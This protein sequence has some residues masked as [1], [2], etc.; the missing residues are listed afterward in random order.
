MLALLLTAVMILTP[1]CSAV[2]AGEYSTKLPFHDTDPEEWY[3]D[4]I[5]YVFDENLMMGKGGG[6]FAPQSGMTRAE[7]ATMLSRMAGADVTG[8][9]EKAKGFSDITGSEWHAAYIGWA[10]EAKLLS[11]YPDGTMKPDNPILRQEI[12]TIISRFV[13]SFGYTLPS[14]VE[15][16]EFDDG[17]DIAEYA[18]P[19]VNRLAAAGIIKGSGG[20]FN[21]QI[22]LTRA[23]ASKIIMMLHGF[24][25]GEEAR[26]T[27]SYDRETAEEYKIWGA[28]HLYYAGT[29]YCGNM[30]STLDES[31]ELP[32]MKFEDCEGATRD[33]QAFMSGNTA[34]APWYIGVNTLILKMDTAKYP[35]LSFKLKLGTDEIQPVT[36]VI[37][38]DAKSISFVGNLLPDGKGYHSVHIDLT[39]LNG[40]TAFPEGSEKFIRVK[41]YPFGDAAEAGN[42]SL[43]YA[44]FFKELDTALSFDA[45][46]ISDYMNTY[47]SDHDFDWREL[48]STA[49]TKYDDAVSARIDDIMNAESIDPATITGKCYY[50]SSVNGD[51]SNTGTSPD[52]PWKTFENLYKW[53]AN[54]TILLNVPKSGDG[55]FLE[56]GSVFYSE[57]ASGD[58]EYYGL[59]VPNGVTL[60]AYGEGD[61]PLITHALDVEGSMDWSKTEYDNIWVLDRKIIMP[62]GKPYDLDVGNI[63]F[64]G[65]E[66]WG[67]K[68]MSEN[69]MEPAGT[70][71]VYSGFVTNGYEVYES[72]GDEFGG[73]GMLKH[74]LEYFHDWSDGS[75]YLYYDKGNPGEKFDSII[76]SPRGYGFG[77]G[78]GSA[79]DG[80]VI[81]NIAIKYLGAHGI[82]SSVAKSLTVQNCEMG[83]IGGS[84]QGDTSVRFGNGIENWGACHGMTVKNCYIYQVYDGTL[85][86]QSGGNAEISENIDFGGNVLTYGN[87]P[88]E[89]WGSNF[90]KNI[91][92]HD[93]YMLYTGFH[94]GHQR[95]AK[96][97]SF[98]CGLG[99]YKTEG[100]ILEDNVMLYGAIFAHV[101]WAFA[102]DYNDNGMIARNNVY[103]MSTRRSYFYRGF[104]DITVEYNIG[105]SN[106]MYYPYTERYMRS[107]ASLGAEQGTTFY[108]YEY[109]ITEWEDDGAYRGTNT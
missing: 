51:D 73:A 28:K 18:V 12:V 6:D 105:K 34:K 97:S 4:Y 52:S 61:K 66:G 69:P 53:G 57:F 80:V 65:G 92:V 8:F 75:L 21:P 2:S 48:T 23:E 3:A 35:I 74:N 78:S 59:T 54:H 62:D 67:I 58:E 91:R 39:H 42:V 14:D 45:T 44:G 109:D 10:V 95:P 106:Y 20:R 68:V 82:T 47:T 55:I 32:L 64:N 25:N 104:E 22:S 90:Y 40:G 19:Y 33:G 77:A 100:W 27:L 107:L 83:W 89:I 86:T 16:P 41:V 101:G 50:I 108:W 5:S 11:G 70:K 71:T 37:E 1:L 46:S 36:G 103:A 7:I 56:R 38:T 85:S 76:I 81:D 79:T 29:A 87:S 98:N 17:D 93:N 15:V 99:D 84:T 88:I 31:G 60:S 49:K 43:L 94:F 96:N 72:G 30:T 24:M 63:V 13:D 26:P 9:A 102:S